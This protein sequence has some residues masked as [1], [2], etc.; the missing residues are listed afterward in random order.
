MADFAARHELVHLPPA[1]TA[2]L[3]LSVLEAGTDVIAL[4]FGQAF[5]DLLVLVTEG[6]GGR[7]VEHDGGFRYEPSGLEPVI[8]VGSRRGVPYRS[9]MDYRLVGPPARLPKFLDDAT[10][11]R[12]AERGSLE[13]RRDVLP[14]VVSEVS[15]AYYHELFHAHPGRTTRSWDWFAPRF[16]AAARSRWAARTMVDRSTNSRR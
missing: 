1:H 9:K 13:F 12:L 2:E 7:F 14:L 8:H 5:T 3:D 10:I 16:T 4:G 15:W 11:T 6:R